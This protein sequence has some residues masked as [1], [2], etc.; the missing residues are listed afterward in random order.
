MSTG[1]TATI[2]GVEVSTEHWIGGRRVGSDDTFP[3][4]SPIDGEIIARVARG[5]AHVRKAALL[6]GVEVD[7]QQ[8]G[9]ARLVGL[10]EP[11]VE[12][13]DVLAR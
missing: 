6:R 10:G 11:A 9:L 1:G 4:I 8:V 13:H 3:D 7:D 12:G 2:E 5:G